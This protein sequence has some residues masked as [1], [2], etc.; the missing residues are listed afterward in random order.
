M[1]L[2]HMAGFLGKTRMRSVLAACF[3]SRGIVG[4]NYHR[5]GD[6]SRSHLDRGLWSA[7]A[8]IFDRQIAWL[9]QNCDVIASSDIEQAQRDPRGLHVLVTFDDGYLDNYQL[10]FPILR[11]HAVPATFFIATGF[12][13]DPCLPWWDEIAGIV[14]TSKREALELPEWLGAPLPLVVGRREPVIR[15][16]LRTYKSLSCADASRFLAAL[17]AIASENFHDAGKDLW[18]NWDMIRD[19]AANGMT[20]GGHTVS[21]IVLSGASRERQWEE[22]STCAARIR[23]EITKPMEY[24]AYPVGG[25]NSFNSDSKDCLRRIGVRYAFSYYGGFATAGAD[26]YDMPRMAIEPYV[27]GDWFKAI[28]QLPR[29]FCR[30]AVA[31]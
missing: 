24:F 19:M 9:K 6:G 29:L 10:A 25:R 17:R 13:D 18:M 26:P 23:A 28:V 5:I 15:M 14:R 3:P 27:D 31:A 4:L 8:E 12:I 16:L 22:I 1:K 11:S 30:A 7:S 2:R 20:I 21:H